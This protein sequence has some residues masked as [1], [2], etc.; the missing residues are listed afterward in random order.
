MLLVNPPL[1]DMWE[2]SINGLRSFSGYAA[3]VFGQYD[4]NCELAE[5]FKQNEYLDIFNDVIIIKNANHEFKGMLEEFIN[6]PF[7]YL[8]NKVLL[9]A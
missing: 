6:L 4:P 9:Y 8:Y 7:Q 1:N 5:L 2:L 3:L